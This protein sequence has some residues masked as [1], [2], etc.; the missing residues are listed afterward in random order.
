MQNCSQKDLQFKISP[1]N[2]GTSSLGSLTPLLSDGGVGISDGPDTEDN[3]LA[4]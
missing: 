3:D 2:V 1:S 4:F